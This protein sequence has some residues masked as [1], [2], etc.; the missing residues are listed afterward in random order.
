[1]RAE[2]SNFRVYSSLSE[3]SSGAR[4]TNIVDLVK[5]NKIEKKKEQILKI[6][7][8]SGFVGLFLFFVIFIFI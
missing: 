6:Y 2:K 8:L 4:R 5:K 1:M 7:T 3:I